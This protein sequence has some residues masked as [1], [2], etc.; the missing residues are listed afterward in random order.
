M[1]NVTNMLNAFLAIALIILIARGAMKGASGIILPIVSLVVAVLFTKPV[2]LIVEPVFLPFVKGAVADAFGTIG[3]SES[4]LFSRLPDYVQLLIS[5]LLVNADLS[6]WISI[7][8]MRIFVFALISAA[9]TLI[10]SIIK[11]TEN[12]FPGIKLLDAIAGGVIGFG[13]F[14][15]ISMITGSLGLTT[16]SVNGT[17]NKVLDLARQLGMAIK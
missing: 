7:V 9:I 15:L 3:G 1:G 11:G 14:Y 4:L 12:A 8:L 10:G 2:C 16:L 6:S 17:V 13:E 5:R